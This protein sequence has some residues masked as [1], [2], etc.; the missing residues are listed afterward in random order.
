MG[1]DGTSR[2]FEL[3]N[4]GV[5]A[6]VL[7]IEDSVS[8]RALLV[9]RLQRS[10]YDVFAAEGG[11]AGLKLLYEVRPEIVLLDIV[12]PPP[13][14]WKTL[15]LIRQVSDVPVIMVTSLDTDIDRVRG[16]RGGADDYIAK[17]YSGPELVARVEAVLRRT[18]T[19]QVRDVQ[20]DGVVRIDFEAA[21]V[22]VRGAPVQLT[23]LE[24]R[25]LTAFVENP[26]NV[27]S[28][29][30]LLELVWGGAGTGGDQVKLYVAYLRRKIERDPTHPELIETVR[31]FG[32][33]YRPL[34]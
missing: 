3:R 30:Q 32:Y 12:M 22:T 7:V 2:A 14:G 4:I 10:G 5:S 15:E 18:T 9:D 24:F 8:E 11:R 21:A 17:P 25:L 6:R 1:G 29:N 13:D 31:G 23:P 33:R 20:D 28:R 26:G 34:H 19:P 27:L 16:L